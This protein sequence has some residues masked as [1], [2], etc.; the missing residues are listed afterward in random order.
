MRVKSHYAFSERE[1]R[2]MNFKKG[3]I[4]H[5]TETIN[6]NGFRIAK[7]SSFNIVTVI[8]HQSVEA[9]EV[10]YQSNEPIIVC[11]CHIK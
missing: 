1:C 11:K 6:G 2:Q 10:Q 3:T 7:G 4:V 5:M 9:Y 8:K